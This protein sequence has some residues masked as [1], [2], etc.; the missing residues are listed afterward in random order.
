MAGWQW[1]GDKLPDTVDNDA[2]TSSPEPVSSIQSQMR[3]QN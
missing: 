1:A 3:L 2:Q